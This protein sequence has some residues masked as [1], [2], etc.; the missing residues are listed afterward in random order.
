MAGSNKEPEAAMA[1][2]TN[3]LA[4]RAGLARATAAPAAHTMD[5]AELYR[6]HHS[7]VLKAAYRITGSMSDAE[8]VLQTVF[9]RLAGRDFAKAAV[10]NIQGY[11]HRAAVNAALDVVRARQ[12]GRQQALDATFE[13]PAAG[14]HGSPERQRASGEVRT[15][16]QQALGRVSPR[17]AEAFALRYLEEI[18]NQEIAKLM[19]MSESAVGVMLHRTRT[20]LQKDYEQK[21]GRQTRRGEAQ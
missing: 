18:D 17:A 10:S 8:D 2:A 12:E 21:V 16:L 7:L 6:A 5:L 14:A 1:S 9:L 3:I 4:G 13:L 15:W 11:L 20:Q 19:G